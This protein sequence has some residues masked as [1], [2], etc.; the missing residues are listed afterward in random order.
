MKPTVQELQQMMDNDKDYKYNYKELKVLYPEKDFYLFDMNGNA[1]KGSEVY[2][3]N[4]IE[5]YE[6]LQNKVNC[7]YKNYGRDARYETN[8]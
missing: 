6:V 3:Y 8:G 4:E 7:Y 5:R 2:I 1:L